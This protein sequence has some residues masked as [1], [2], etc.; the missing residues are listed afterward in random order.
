MTDAVV[1]SGRAVAAP[2]QELGPVAAECGSKRRAGASL[3]QSAGAVQ[4]SGADEVAGGTWGSGAL[5]SPQAGASS[6]LKASLRR[7]V[8]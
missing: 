6:A 1:D 2:K 3:L 8:K 4:D 5:R 7:S